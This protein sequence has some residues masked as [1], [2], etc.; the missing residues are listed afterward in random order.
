MFNNVEA[1]ARQVLQKAHLEWIEFSEA[2]EQ[3]RK[4]YTDETNRSAHPVCRSQPNRGLI[5]IHSDAALDSN[6]CKT[7]KLS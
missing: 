2:Q 5:R 6:L 7:V 3:G 4:E 1:N